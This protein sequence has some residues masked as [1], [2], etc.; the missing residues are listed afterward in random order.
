VPALP[1]ASLMDVV[2][3]VWVFMLL[4]SSGVWWI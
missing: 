1:W 2:S 4:F 3:R